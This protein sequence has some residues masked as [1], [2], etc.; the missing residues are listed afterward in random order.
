MMAKPMKTLELHYPMIQFLIIYIIFGIKGHPKKYE[1]IVNGLNQGV[2]VAGVSKKHAKGTKQRVSA[3]NKE[4]GEGI[5]RSTERLPVVSFPRTFRTQTIRTQAQT[6][7]DILP[8]LFKQAIIA[9]N[10]LIGS[11]HYKR[12]RRR[13][14]IEFHSLS[15]FTLTITQ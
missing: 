6:N 15:H 5:R 14:I 10:K 12:L 4:Q 8:L 1:I 3:K 9:P 13:I 11:Q 2:S 7:V